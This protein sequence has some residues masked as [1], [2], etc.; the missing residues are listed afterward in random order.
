MVSGGYWRDLRGPCCRA[1]L[2]RNTAGDSPK[3][4]VW[5]RACHERKP[6][7]VALYKLYPPWTAE[8]STDHKSG[9][10]TIEQGS[11]SCMVSE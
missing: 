5:I 3:R 11:F 4:L 7:L 9:G 2:L 10:L 1:Y 6:P 8:I